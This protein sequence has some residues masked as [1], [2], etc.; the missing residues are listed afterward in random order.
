[1]KK[2]SFIK[3]I[4]CPGCT[5][6][7]SETDFEK[8]GMKYVRCLNCG[9]SYV[10]PRPSKADLDNFYEQSEAVR[11][12][13][14][15]VVQPTAE[16]RRQY[17]VGPRTSWVLETASTYEQDHGIF[18]DFYSK[19]PEYLEQIE[20]RGSFSQTL[21]RRSL[22]SFPQHLSEVIRETPELERSSVAVVS[23]FEVLERLFDPRAFL[24]RMYEVLENN[25]LLFLTTLSISGFD[26]SL[27][28]GTARNLLPPTHLTILSYSGIQHIM[29]HAGFEIVEL[30]TPG[31]LDVALVLDALQRDDKLSLPP[32]V[33]TILLERGDR[34]HEAFQDFLQQ[35]NL[36]SHVWIVARKRLD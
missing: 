28:R 33:Q 5:H 6:H 23:A 29:N 18:I 10:T 21:T 11:Y 35:A 24:A 27:L 26:L 2:S 20:K 31:R 9:T 13:D 14:S 3:I 16:A 4:E 12:W 22:V 32:I 15:S 17:I 34:I 19:Y 8:M 30:S 25:G 36:S 7:A 1:M